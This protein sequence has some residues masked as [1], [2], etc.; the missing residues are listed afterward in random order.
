M[1]TKV[2][3]YSSLAPPPATKEEELASQRAAWSKIVAEGGATPAGLAIAKQL[4]VTIPEGY[5]PQAAI[6]EETSKQLALMSA[7][8]LVPAGLE[9]LKMA[10][11]WQI[12]QGDYTQKGAQPGAIVPEGVI[13]GDISTYTKLTGSMLPAVGGLGG[14]VGIAGGVAG[15]ANFLMQNWPAIAGVLGIGAAGGAAGAGLTSLLGGLGGGG[16]TGGGAVTVDG[17]P[18]SGPGVPEPPQAM[19]AK[20]WVTLAHSNVVGNYYIYFFK[21]VDGRIMC[22]NA[23][24]KEWKIWRPK[25]MIVLSPDPRMSMIRKLDRVYNRTMKRLAK[26]SKA[27]KLA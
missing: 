7:G 4:G 10:D 12:I 9:G 5:K 14:A 25:K 16:V 13:P 8:A 2:K 1:A 27:L 23:A 20:Q 19:V 22:Y 18:I 6:A 11:L 3:R 21:L 24:K 17:V 26:K 15:I